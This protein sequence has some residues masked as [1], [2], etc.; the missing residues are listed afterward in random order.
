MDP[1]AIW[2]VWLVVAA[3]ALMLLAGSPVDDAG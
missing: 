2:P 3:F 1:F